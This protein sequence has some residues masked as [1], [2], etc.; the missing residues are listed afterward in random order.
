MVVFIVII[1]LVILATVFAVAFYR[2]NKKYDNFIVQNSVSLS[3]LKGINAKYAFYPYVSYDQSHTYDNENF[4]NDISCEDYLIYQLQYIGNRVSEQIEKININ[5]KLYSAYLHELDGIE[6]LGQFRAP[7]GNL[8]TDKL[9]K[10]EKLLMSK[11]VLNKPAVSFNID[12]TLNRSDINGYIYQRKEECFSPKDI[13]ILIKRLKNKRGSFYNNRYIWDAICRVERG[14][15]SNKIRFAIYERDGYRCCRCGISQRY[16]ALEID[17]IIPIAKGGKSTYD[18]LQTLC[19][20]CN[21]E[22]GD[23]M[24]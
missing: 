15:V 9:L 18:N 16:A 4:Y 24:Y 22:K 3:T 8:K 2:R 10:K 1:S 12:V 13:L 6:C 17:H 20:K 7:V 11:S 21:V 23:T 14:K 5:S 19:H